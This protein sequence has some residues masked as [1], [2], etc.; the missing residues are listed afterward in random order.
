VLL[1]INLAAEDGFA[2]SASLASI[3]PTAR[4]I[5]MSSDLDSVRS[6]DLQ[7]C[8]AVAFLAKA[9]LASADLMELFAG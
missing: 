3:C 4:I 8:G 6:S 5:L 9:D 2:V 7:Q 1:D